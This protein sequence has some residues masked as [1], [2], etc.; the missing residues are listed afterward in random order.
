[1]QGAWQG[2]AWVRQLDTHEYEDLGLEVRLDILAT[3]VACV[4]EG[5]TLRACLDMRLEENQRIRRQMFEEARVRPS[6]SVHLWS[7]SS[8]TGS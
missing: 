3:L 4:L 1:M 8:C 5:P 2:A 6:A 7:P